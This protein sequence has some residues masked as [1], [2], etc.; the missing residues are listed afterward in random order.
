MK[1]VS[2]TRTRNFFAA[3]LCSRDVVDRE[4]RGH[5]IEGVIGVGEPR[6]VA[7][8]ERDAIGHAVASDVAARRVDRV[9]GLVHASPEVDP[10]HRGTRAGQQT[11]E[12]PVATTDIQGARLPYI[13][14][15]REEGRSVDEDLRARRHALTGR[16]ALGSIAGLTPP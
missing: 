13:A 8:V 3:A 12:I 6:H 7:G 14:A 1:E 9:A 11:A 15:R 2:M 4:A 16:V 5:Q 10:R